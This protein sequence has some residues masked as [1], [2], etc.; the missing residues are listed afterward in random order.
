[1]HIGLDLDAGG[2]LDLEQVALAGLD[3]QLVSGLQL[4]GR[5]CRQRALFAENA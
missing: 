5:A 3:L 2:V 4:R 1:M